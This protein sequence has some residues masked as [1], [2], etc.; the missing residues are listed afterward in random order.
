MSNR[1]PS[2]ARSVIRSS[3]EKQR[4]AYSCH[5][6]KSRHPLRLCR[7]FLGMSISGRVSAVEKYKYCR[8]CL[9]HEHSH[10]SCFSSQ[11]CK[12][13]HKRHHTLL[14]SSAERTQ[15]QRRPQTEDRSQPEGR[16]QS[17]GRSCPEVTPST[18]RSISHQTLSSFMRQNTVVLVPT[19]VVYISDGKIQSTARCLL[20]SGSTISRISKRFTDSIKLTTLTLDP[21]S[22]C[23]LTLTSRFDAERHIDV[24]LRVN[25]R[26]NLKTPSKNLPADVK[27]NFINLCL[28]DSNF[29]ERST[30]DIIIG[31]DIYT[32]IVFDGSIT[33]PGLPTALNTIFGWAIYGP[34]LF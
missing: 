13:C 18:S 3:V 17:E 9:A 5:V 30:V 16:S 15:R 21:E 7:K 28:A 25:S 29:F 19:I 23:P 31:A 14:H 22:L 20:D 33:R 27:E 10:G 4:P 24:M 6:C 11:G 26:M 34:H 32:K 8:N 12:K 1:S 2:R